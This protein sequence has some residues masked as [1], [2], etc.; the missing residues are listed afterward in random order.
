MKCS[1]ILRFVVAGLQTRAGHG[2]KLA[3]RVIFWK[4]GK[5]L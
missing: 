5:C 4:K 3:M 2:V 1:R